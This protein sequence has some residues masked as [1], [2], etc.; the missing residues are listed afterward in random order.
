MTLIQGTQQNIIFQIVA[1][2]MKLWIELKKLKI[3]NSKCT[4]NFSKSKTWIIWSNSFH[5]MTSL[6]SIFYSFQFSMQ[7]N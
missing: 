6:I 3:N 2:E 4:F 7:L 5:N 1:N